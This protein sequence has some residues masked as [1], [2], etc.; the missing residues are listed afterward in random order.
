MLIHGGDIYTYK[1]M[2]DFSANLNPLGLPESVMEAAKRGCEQAAAYPDPLCRE[3]TAAIAEHEGVV[4]QQV[5]C[6]NGAADLIFR[7]AWAV[8]PKRALLIAPTFAEYEQ[9][10]ASVGCQ[11]EHHY[12]SEE[13]GW[14]L[15]DGYLHDL[16]SRPDIVFICNPNNPTGVTV[17]PKLLR[18]ILSK[19][20]ALG[21]RLAVDECFNDF[22]PD[23]EEHTLKGRLA[24][25]QH[26]FILKAF[27]KTYAMAGLRLGYGLSADMELLRV[28]QQSAQPWS[29]STPAQSAGIAALSEQAYV[30]RAHALV[31]AE[32]ERL[33][34]ELD[35][36]GCRTYDS[37]ANYI[38][39]KSV[40]GLG[41]ACR[42]HGVLIR[43]CANYV[44]LGE[45]YYRVAVKLPQENDK[46]LQ[47]LKIALGEL[48]SD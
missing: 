37:R 20:A 43:D 18:Q 32:R 11:I 24:K 8:R 28:M 42:R 10:L 7:L 45:G 38:F 13:T 47:C 27:T 35:K 48:C 1:G 5:I 39:F 23:G 34:G 19:T 30:R 17:E 26:L 12:L 16:D 15:G 3:L 14:R 44:G 22:L 9:A 40:A 41:E 29:V 31:Q 36:L 21:I 25:N 46:L 2:L 6:G 33:L 4:A